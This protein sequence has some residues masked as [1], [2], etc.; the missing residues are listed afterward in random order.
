MRQLP[1]PLRWHDI[2]WTDDGPPG[3]VSR[4]TEDAAIRNIRHQQRAFTGRRELEPLERI[5]Y[6]LELL[7]IRDYPRFMTPEQRAGWIARHGRVAIYNLDTKAVMAI[8]D[9]VSRVFEYNDD[10]GTYEQPL[11]L[12][13]VMIVP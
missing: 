7:C 11:N 13:R 3:T 5:I 6:D 4:P 12:H 1:L 10:G 2:D 8:L 9:D